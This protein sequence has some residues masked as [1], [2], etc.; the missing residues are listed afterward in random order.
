MALDMRDLNILGSV[1]NT[2]YG[3]SSQSQK[4]SV[5]N[6]QAK[7]HGEKMVITC[8]TIINLIDSMMMDGEVKRCEKECNQVINHYV[9][10]I[11]K[12]FKSEAK[13]ALKIKKI[14]NSENTSTELAGYYSPHS[15]V[16][17]AFIRRSISFDIG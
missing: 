5:Y 8:I 17:T 11:K 3:N 6:V 13:K 14:K 12:D 1:I 4:N 10:Q 9:S 16:R 7:M 15:P 2:T